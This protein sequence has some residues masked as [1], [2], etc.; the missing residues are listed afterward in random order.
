MSVNTMGIEQA[1]TLITELHKEATGRQAIQPVDLSSFISVAQSTLQAGYD[2]V[3]NAISQVISRTIVSV[4][5]YE[6]IKGSADALHRKWKNICRKTHI[7]RNVTKVITLSY[8]RSVYS[9]HISV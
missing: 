4:R 8:F 9:R 1:Y 2:T 5:P 7:N 6:R 3:L